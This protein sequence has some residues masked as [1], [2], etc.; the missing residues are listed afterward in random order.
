MIVML[1]LTGTMPFV[2][3]YFLVH[4]PVIGVA[5]RKNLIARWCSAMRLGIDAGLDLPAAMDLAAQSVDSPQ[6]QHDTKLLIDTLGAGGHLDAVK[7][8]LLPPILPA[9]IELG[10]SRGDLAGTL[11]A[12]SQ[13]NQRQAELRIAAIPVT[14]IPIVLIFFGCIITCIILALFMPIISLIQSMSGGGQHHGWW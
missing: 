1:R 13:M 10:A 6:L 5:I 2:V 9:A 4:L 14:V 11:A 8:S 7:T 3:D 12:L